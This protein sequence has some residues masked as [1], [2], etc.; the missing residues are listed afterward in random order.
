MPTGSSQGQNA[1]T[2]SSPEEE[3]RQGQSHSS[4][5][6]TDDGRASLESMRLH[7]VTRQDDEGENYKVV[8]QPIVAPHM[9]H[10]RCVPCHAVL[11]CA[12]LCYAVLSCAVLCC[13]VLCCVVL[14]CAGLLVLC[15]PTLIG[16]N[17]L[18]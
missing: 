7:N 10:P 15:C 12:V 16:L 6:G 2:S 17:V 5:E 4:E 11:C 8:P 1:V 13:A 9:I 14:C 18:C 3:G